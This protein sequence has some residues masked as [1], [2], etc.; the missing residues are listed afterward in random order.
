VRDLYAQL[1]DEGETVLGVRVRGKWFDIGSPSLYLASQR[2]L[3]GAGFGGAKG[4]VL[5]HRDARVHRTAKVT[6]S[7]VGA[8]CVVGAGALLT[9]SILWDG[10]TVEAEA[11]VAD[12]IL[13]TGTTASEGEKMT[14]M[15][16]TM[17]KHGSQDA[18]EVSG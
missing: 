11:R 17:G 13:A 9:G 7:V 2:A 4:G 18:V 3:L 12:S 14:G 10:V 5:I 1:V 8:G 6:R 16:V 15:V